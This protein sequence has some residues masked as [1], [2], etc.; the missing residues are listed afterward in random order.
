[1]AASN[2]GMEYFNN[3]LREKPFMLYTDQKPLEKLSHLHTKAMNRLQENR[4][5][6]DF[7]VQ[8]KKGATLL[9][10]FL[11]QDIVKGLNEVVNS[12]DPFC[13]DLQELQKLDK[14]LIKINAFQ[15]DGKWPLNTSKAE[16]KLLFPITYSLFLDSKAVWFRL[17]D[18]DYPKT[19]L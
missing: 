15:K 4:L 8:Y 14:E 3:Y 17:N 10:Y 13:K 7:Q 6:Y 12:I 1:M 2:W 18:D 5:T 19:A 11:S 9:A 16:I